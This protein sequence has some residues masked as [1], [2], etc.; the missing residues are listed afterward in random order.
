MWLMQADRKFVIQYG[1]GFVDI[2]LLCFS[3][4]YLHGWRADLPEPL[5]SEILHQA[6][7]K[8]GGC[9]KQRSQ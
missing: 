1:E 5:D 9:T 7:A 6:R 4:S 8:P 3:R 2:I